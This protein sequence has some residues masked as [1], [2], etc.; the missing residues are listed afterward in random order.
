MR[1]LA[2][3]FALFV[4]LALRL[5]VSVLHARLLLPLFAARGRQ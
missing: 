2:V 1:L 4:K 3:T 5:K